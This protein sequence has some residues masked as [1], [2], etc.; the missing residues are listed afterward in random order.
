MSGYVNVH[1]CMW[2]CVCGVSGYV[3]VHACVGMCGY[4]CVCGYV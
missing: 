2:V 3:N 4:T 1:A